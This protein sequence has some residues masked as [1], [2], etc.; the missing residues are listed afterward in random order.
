MRVK[1]LTALTLLPTLPQSCCFCPFCPVSKQRTRSA[2]PAVPCRTCT[3]PWLHS[4]L[5]LSL[6]HPWA[7]PWDALTPSNALTPLHPLPCSHPR[8]CV[9]TRVCAACR[10][11]LQSPWLAHHHISPAGQRTWGVHSVQPPLSSEAPACREFTTHSHSEG[12]SF[13]SSVC[14]YFSSPRSL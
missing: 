5:L 7:L 13:T 6:L 9:V 12:V 10:D 3:A 14:L 8:V 1:D 4:L 11:T 2:L